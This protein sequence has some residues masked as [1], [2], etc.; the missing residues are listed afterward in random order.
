[1]RRLVQMIF[2]INSVHNMEIVGQEIVVKN[3]WEISVIL[4]RHN[5]W[6]LFNSSAIQN[7]S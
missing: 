6:R 3:V 1:M 2:A 7:V 4:F 5:V